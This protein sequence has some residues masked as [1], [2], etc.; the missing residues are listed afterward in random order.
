MDIETAIAE[1]KAEV[2]RHARDDAALQK[3]YFKVP[4]ELIGH[5]VPELRAL[6]KVVRKACPKPPHDDLIKALD[7][8]WQSKLYEDKLLAILL[9]GYFESQFTAA[10][11]RRVFLPWARELVGWSLLDDLAIHVMGWVALRE[12]A[13]FKDSLAWTREESFWV[14]RAALLIH[15]PA[16]GANALRFDILR[17]SA[18]AVVD[19][20]EFFITK[21]LG[22]VL[23][24]MFDCM[25][26]E[27]E[28][29]FLI[30]GPRAAALT[31]RE[32]LRKL[33]A[34]HRDRLLDAI[35]A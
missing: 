15:L 26:G 17:R 2:R 7:R 18:E 9:A 14:R 33:D 16:I 27:A 21:A 8:L 31:R 10:D 6:S 12:P 13:L 35:S 3:A 19:E 20:R 34:D 32:A 5:R 23:R 4:Y 1:A 29:L 30:V 25:P 28:R 11:V 22:W 24:S